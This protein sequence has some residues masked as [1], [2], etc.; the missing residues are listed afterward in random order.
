MKKEAALLKQEALLAKKEL[1]KNVS[2][3]GTTKHAVG[4][5]SEWETEFPWLIPEKNSMGEVQN[6]CSFQ[7]NIM[8]DMLCGLC[9]LFKI[10]TII[11]N[12]D[13]YCNGRY[14]K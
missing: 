10:F 7:C 14:K 9:V 11:L 13:Q 1:K 8:S 6:L 2:S 12:F 4:Y 5:K 3:S